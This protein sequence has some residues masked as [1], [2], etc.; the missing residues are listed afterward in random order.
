MITALVTFPNHYYFRT[1]GYDLGYVLG[2]F[3]NLSNGRP[4]H[5]V[6]QTTEVQKCRQ[7]IDTSSVRCKEKIQSIFNSFEVPH[8]SFSAYVLG[9]PFYWL[10]GA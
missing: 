8:F 10:G 6:Y 7:K 5:F 9:L 2:V 3:E 4:L 1:Y